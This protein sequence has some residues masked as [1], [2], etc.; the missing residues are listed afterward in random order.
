MAFLPAT[1]IVVEKNMSN[2]SDNKCCCKKP[3]VMPSTLVVAK[4]TSFVSDINCCCKTLVMTATLIVLAKFF[5][6]ALM[7]AIC[8]NIFFAAKNTFCSN[9]AFFAAT[10]VAAKNDI[11]CSGYVQI[12]VKKK[13]LYVQVQLLIFVKKNSSTFF[14]SNQSVY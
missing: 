2:D 13:K 14:H 10:F 12:L 3:L 7:A 8:S 6:T 4:N 1:I 9:F 11:S 5:A